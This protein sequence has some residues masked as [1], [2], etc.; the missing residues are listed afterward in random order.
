MHKSSA[1]TQYSNLCT[2]GKGLSRLCH[3]QNIHHQRQ[4]CPPF[5]ED[6]ENQKEIVL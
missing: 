4:F 5:V 2:E 1:H 6:G 3:M